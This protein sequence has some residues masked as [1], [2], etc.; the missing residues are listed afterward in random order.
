MPVWQRLKDCN[1]AALK[2]AELLG[3]GGAGASARETK[4]SDVGAVFP[5]KPEKRG[6]P[7]VPVQRRTE[8]LMHKVESY[9]ATEEFEDGA[10]PRAVSAISKE[11]EI[12]DT[13]LYCGVTGETGLDCFDLKKK[14]QAAGYKTQFLNGRPG[15]ADRRGSL[16]VGAEAGDVVA[17]GA[18]PPT[19]A[20]SNTS[21][22]SG[23]ADVALPTALLPTIC[24]ANPLGPAS[25][26]RSSS[27][28]LL[29]NEQL[30]A[31]T[32]D[33]CCERSCEHCGVC[34]VLFALGGRWVLATAGPYPVSGGLSAAVGPGEPKKTP[35][36]TTSSALASPR[37][38]PEEKRADGAS[39]G[40]G[41]PSD[42]PPR[43]TTPKTCTP[44]TS[45]GGESGGQEQQSGGEQPLRTG[46]QDGSGSRI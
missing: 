45:A 40:G 28:T 32:L 33:A 5:K 6:G 1:C 15:A 35:P 42:G 26:F 29:D 13:V 44:K 20:S 2:N 21:S 16:G 4:T 19:P 11:I 8:A 27:P 18:A 7:P 43:T 3:T 31:G 36:L 14:Y 10:R 41:G 24:G 39:Q 38:A 12:E 17:V 37:R 34:P 9:L 22:H 25:V 23:A 30:T 46:A